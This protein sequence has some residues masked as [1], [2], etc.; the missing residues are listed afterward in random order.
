MMYIDLII[1]LVIVS[2]ISVWLDRR[3]VRNKKNT[4]S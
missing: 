2:L 4:P 3:Y 1:L